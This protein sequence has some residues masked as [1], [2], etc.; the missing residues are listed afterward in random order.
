MALASWLVPLFVL[1]LFVGNFSNGFA[2]KIDVIWFSQREINCTLRYAGDGVFAGKRTPCDTYGILIIEVNFF[3][4]AGMPTVRLGLF[5]IGIAK[6]IAI[7]IFL[8]TTTKYD[9]YR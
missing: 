1:W 6:P 2:F 4:W 3:L 5:S 8:T 7:A 9:L